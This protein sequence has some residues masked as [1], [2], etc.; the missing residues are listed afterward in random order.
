M[1]SPA[2]TNDE[3]CD[4]TKLCSLAAYKLINVLG[5]NA[6][7]SSEFDNWQLTGADELVEG[8]AADA[9]FFEGLLERK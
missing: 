7:A 8:R 3:G 4:A 2:S 5:C 1:S 6:L 9:E